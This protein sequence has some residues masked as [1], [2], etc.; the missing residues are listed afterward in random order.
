MIDWTKEQIRKQHRAFVLDHYQSW[1]DAAVAEW[2]EDAGI[3]KT[4]Q[5]EKH[6]GTN[7]TD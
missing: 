5:G 2:G 3:V 4:Q 1:K 7:N 6:E